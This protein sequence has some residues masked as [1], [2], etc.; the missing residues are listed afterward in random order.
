M[1]TLGRQYATKLVLDNP[2]KPNI[3]FYLLSSICY[4]TFG[5]YE[6]PKPPQV[7]TFL[8]FIKTLAKGAE[9]KTKF[10][11]DI[12]WLP[13][14]FQNVTLQTHA[15]RYQCAENHPLFV[16][17]QRYLESETSKNSSPRLDII[18]S[19]ISDRRIS[20]FENTKVMGNWEKL[21][22][23]AYKFKSP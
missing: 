8:Q 23:N 20:L 6:T 10:Q 5:T 9:N 16:E 3:Q 22:A 17:M 14:K 11:V 12:I 15:F 4:M 13:G 2:N 1:V 21:G 19:S 18:I 7:P